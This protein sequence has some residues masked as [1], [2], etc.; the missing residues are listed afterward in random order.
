MLEIL[1]SYKLDQKVD[2]FSVRTTRPHGG[3]PDTL[4]I[5]MLA[6]LGQEAD[7]WCMSCACPQDVWQMFWV[8]SE[9]C[10]EGVYLVTTG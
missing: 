9:M 10:Q 5:W 6:N 4:T 1:Q 3:P 8:V 7:S 2:L